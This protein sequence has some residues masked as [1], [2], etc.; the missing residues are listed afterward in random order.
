MSQQTSLTKP[1]EIIVACTSTG[2]IGK[3]G[4]LPWKLAGDMA[5]FKRT[6][7]DTGKEDAANL[8]NAV[9]M[10]R[11]TWE[12]I[13]AKFRPLA[14]RLNVVLSRNPAS[15]E[16]PEGVL[17]C[18]SLGDAI[19][20]VDGLADVCKCFIIGGQSVY[21]EAFESPRLSKVRFPLAPFHL[22]QQQREC[23]L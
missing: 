20:R 1:M 17:T 21:T 4:N 18:S 2:G 8:R 14:G 11:K 19:A 13:P 7:M 5:Y 10:G 15:L 3:D 22:T 6:T 12:S 16:L 23:F 9:V